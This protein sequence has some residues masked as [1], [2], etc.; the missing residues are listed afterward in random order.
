MLTLIGVRMHHKD[1]SRYL[2]CGVKWTCSYNMAFA[3]VGRE[4]GGRG[5][6]G[7]G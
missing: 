3:G 6:G 5:G 1:P 7:G 4:V 2:N